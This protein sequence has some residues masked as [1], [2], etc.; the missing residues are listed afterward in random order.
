VAEQIRT[1]VLIAGGGPVGL[2]TA[3]ELGQRGVACILLNDKPDT[4]FHPKANAIGS[5][6]ME[7]FRRLG[8]AKAVRAS[9]LDDDHPTDVAYFTRLTGREIA[10][11]HMPSRADALRQARDGTSPWPSAEPPHRCSQIFLERCLKSRADEMRSADIR[12][13][14]KLT[15][16]REETD[17]V[18]GT[19][20]EVATG[21]TVEIAADYLVGADAGSSIVRKTLGIE[22]AGESGV[23]RQFMGGQMLA[24]YFRTR[25]DP[26]WLSVS[27]SWQ[28]W[29]VAPDIRAVFIHVKSHDHM[30]FMTNLPAGTDPRSVDFAKLNRIAA[31]APVPMEIIST[32]PWTAGY[33]LVAQ[34]FGR[35]R[36]FLAGDS[37]HLFTPT[38]GL[39]MNTGIDDAV[40]LAWKLAA[41]VQGWGGANLGA[42][43]ET[44]RR[45]I[46]IRNVG[47]AR[48]FAMSVGTVPVT[49]AIERDD[50]EGREERAKLG[51]R[52]ND[53]AFREFIIPGIQLGLRYDGSPIVVP[54]GTPPPPDET[55]RYVQTAFPGARAP[56]LWVGEDVSLHDRFGRDFT[57][58]KLRGASER[59]AADIA[60][61]ARA[62]GVPLTVLNVPGDAARELYGAELALARPDH[63]VAWRGARAADPAALIDRVRGA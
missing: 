54:D 30:L 18:V 20:E 15:A 16:W 46:G 5:R 36:V 52:L 44:E 22:Y 62:R 33:S 41:L 55:T 4:A 39:G 50:A 31:G 7:H 56:H 12:F 23:V 13:G 45:P 49:A 26:A 14:W 6:T 63:H 38:G 19:A 37:A 51:A 1:S 27:R 34:S 10:R 3:I 61:V 29:I 57:L 8:V 21:R 11:L 24:C 58:L 43:Y 53:H 47:Y 48:T 32:L 25:I 35:G 2:V 40:N 9:G 42:S 28:Y 59:D 17:G 60:E